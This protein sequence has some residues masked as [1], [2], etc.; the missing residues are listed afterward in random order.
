M[1]RYIVL[2]DKETADGFGVEMAY[3]KQEAANMQL[4][5][6]A[7]N[8]AEDGFDILKWGYAHSDIYRLNYNVDTDTY[9]YIL[10][11]DTNDFK[12]SNKDKKWDYWFKRSW[13]DHQKGWQAYSLDS[14]YTVK[15]N[16]HSFLLP[17]DCNELYF[18]VAD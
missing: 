16:Y 4:S 8:E 13:F 7:P 5:A 15:H 17:A 2:T 3:T 11:N 12:D 9:M 1:F 18:G 10:W 14:Q 6:T